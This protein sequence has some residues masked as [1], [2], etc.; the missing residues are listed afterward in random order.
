MNN[1]IFR[2]AM[3]NIQK[4]TDMKLVTTEWKENT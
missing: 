3:E 2:K 1:S 4:H